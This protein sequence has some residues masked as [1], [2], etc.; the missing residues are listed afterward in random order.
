MV[1]VV[2]FG[3]SGFRDVVHIF[4]DVHAPAEGT[5]TLFQGKEQ[6]SLGDGSNTVLRILLLQRKAP[7]HV[8]T[9][10]IEANSS[11]LRLHPLSRSHGTHRGKSLDRQ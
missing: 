8:R 9:E 10:L 11:K 1:L 5:A 3:F 7:L 4:V 6:K 2:V